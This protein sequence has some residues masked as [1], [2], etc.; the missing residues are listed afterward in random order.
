MSLVLICH[1]DFGS[2]L[3]GLPR[4][5]GLAPGFGFVLRSGGVA[6]R[7]LSVAASR[8]SAFESELHFFSG[9]AG[10]DTMGGSDDLARFL[11]GNNPA[12]TQSKIHHL[13]AVGFVA[14]YWAALELNIDVNAVELA[15]ANSLAFS[16]TAQLIGASRRLD[17]YISI[18][19]AR[20]S[21][22]FNEKLEAFAKETIAL[23]ERRNRV[24]HD[25]WT[26][27]HNGKHSRFELTARRRPKKNLS[28]SP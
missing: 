5:L 11:E 23:S 28:L 8:R 4:F 7:R 20:G 24:I 14:T 21:K 10:E 9:H 16:F 27:F 18:A 22:K 13:A 6:R 19:R 12:E 1:W 17:A 15:N 3:G 26:F 2:P 25:P